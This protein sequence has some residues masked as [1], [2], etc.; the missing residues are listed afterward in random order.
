MLRSRLLALS[1]PLLLLLVGCPGPRPETLGDT[2]A[3]NG[4]SVIYEPLR[5]PLPEVPFPSDL[6]TRIDH[7]SHT[8]R[9]LNLSAASPLVAERKIRNQLDRLDGFSVVAPITVSFDAP[10]DLATVTDDT[11]RVID[12]TPG[13]PEYGR[14][15]PLDLGRG[16]YPARFR[17]RGLFP[18]DANADAPD[19]L[20]G[21]DN[22]VDGQRVEHWEVET[23][24]LILRPMYA[25]R[26]KTTYAVVITAAVKGVSG[27]SVRSPFAGIHP[28]S[29]AAAL[30][31][32]RT[33][34]T[35]PIAFT[36]SFT[37]QSITDDMVLLRNGMDGVGP[38]AWVRDQYPARLL[39]VTDMGTDADGDGTYAD[40]GIPYVERDHRWILQPKYV[41]D[42]IIKPIAPALK[43]FGL[44]AFSMDDVDYVVFG[45]LESPDFRSPEDRAIWADPR[46]GAV[47]HAPGEVTFLLTV[48]KT[49]PGVHEP[50][51]P[52]IMY[53]HGA[54]TSR[55]ELMLIAN[56]M[57]K[58][59]FAMMGIDAAGH[60]PFVG[61][62]EALIAQ[63]PLDIPVDVLV[64][65]VGSLLGKYMVGPDYDPTGK[66]LREL[67]DDFA[68]NGLWNAIFV[69]GRSEDLDGDG[70]LVS[71]DGYF[72][73]N[74]FQL[75]SSTRQ[76]I[77]DT[78]MAFRMIRRFDPEAVPPA[79]GKPREASF[80]ELWPHFAAGDFNADGVLDVGGPGNRY[81][82]MGTSLGGIHTSILMALEPDLQ[83]G[84]PI[85]SGG[86]MTDIM[87][88]TTLV[89]AV[90]AIFA[91]AAGPAV[92]GCPVTNEDGSQEVALTWNNYSLR[93]ANERFISAAE[94]VRVPSLAGGSAEL[95]NPRLHREGGDAYL[96]EALRTAVIGDTGG[97]SVAVAADA[98][99]ILELT[100]RD[101]QGVIAV[102]K[103]E[104]VAPRDGLGRARNRPGMRRLLNIAQIGADRGDPL[105]YARNLLR[106]PLDG[107]APRNILHLVAVGDRT[108]PFSS[109]VA[110]DRTAG[111]HGMDDA[112]L[113]V[114]RAFADHQSLDGTGPLWDVDNR[115]AG[116]PGDGIG[117]LAVIRSTG[118]GI[119]GVRHATTSS[120]EFIAVSK[121]GPNDWSVYHQSQAVWFLM[122]DG[123][124]IS[125]DP[126]LNDGSCE[127][128]PH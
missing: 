93:C 85:V 36:W 83:T 78:M 71:G 56:R 69:Q 99:D 33:L 21:E 35:Q 40:L 49:V 19:L 29:Q 11:V 70:V 67:L 95:Y 127:F 72:V 18:F 20:F 51:F 84:V 4:P 64:P 74:P 87:A 106:E 102:P 100:L 91:E 26:Q 118:G 122:T 123:R 7:T 114:T 61:D 75:A 16:A 79:V 32:L 22:V 42:L 59:G 3:G 6:A 8:G 43:D 15:I 104:L 17:P 62:L 76:T 81:Y 44:D 46:T 37:T 53:S 57:A 88:R 31:P 125:D 105:A 10:V 25:L 28:A 1:S 121:P 126:C 115:V 92:V 128:L 14:Q 108:V 98:G 52:V 80:E 109:S 124:E 86:G 54:R 30:A 55:F 107:A 12:V 65:V 60:G 120:H 89:T 94:V 2:P 117:P 103:M 77:L 97:F 112:A 110:W 111:L 113:D 39:S 101:A 96:E 90:D 58:A 9:R 119:S 5:E 68:E 34:V 23:N 63:Q 116:S 66:S 38:F 47:D 13:S 27:E 73:P 82:A 50:P 45:T 41:S 48:P 24:T